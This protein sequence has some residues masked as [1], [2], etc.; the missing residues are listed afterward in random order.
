MF[1]LKA[2]S[3]SQEISQLADS[4]VQLDLKPFKHLLVKFRISDHSPSVQSV[5]NIDNQL[6]FLNI[7]NNF[8]LV[9]FIRTPDCYKH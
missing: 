1:S 3:L 5:I 7:L 4:P 8:I 6:L 9:D 2:E